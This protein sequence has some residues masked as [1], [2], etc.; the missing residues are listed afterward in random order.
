MTRPRRGE[1]QRVADESPDNHK[2]EFK[3]VVEGNARELHPMVLEESYHI[4]PEALMNALNY[5]GGLHIEAEIAYDA[6]QF[7][8]RNRDDGR[9]ID[10][11]ILEHGGRTGHW[12]LQGMR[13]RAQRIG[14]QLEFCSRPGTGAE[15][16]LR[17]PGPTACRASGTPSK[18]MWLA[19]A[20]DREKTS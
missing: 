12:N 10:P 9:G 13:E 17:V 5:S 16:E 6:K 20:F 3:A 4:G 18:R 2:S 11:A 8:L 15:V 19:R 7:R 14:G 1:R